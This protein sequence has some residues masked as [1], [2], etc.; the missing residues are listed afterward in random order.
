M[1]IARQGKTI[2]KGN[3][4]LAELKREPKELAQFLFRENS[5][6]QGVFLM[7]GTGIVPED[8]FTLARGDAIRISI[9]GIGTLEN[10]VA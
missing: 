7:T 1:E 2:F 6:P 10:H 9:D 3:T 5:F 8:D 4:T